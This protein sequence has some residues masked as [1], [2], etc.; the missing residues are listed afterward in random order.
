MPNNAGNTKNFWDSFIRA[1][2]AD[3]RTA[4]TIQGASGIQHPVDAIGM[5]EKYKRLIIVSNTVD[6]YSAA[7]VQADI[8]SA[9]DGIKVIVTRPIAISLS[10]TAQAL[11]TQMG[12]TSFNLTNLLEMFSDKEAAT[13][14]LE[15][16]IAP[17]VEMFRLSPINTT[18]K[19][20]QTIQ[21][22]TKIKF[23]F[24]LISGESPEMID[25]ETEDSINLANLINEDPMS[26]DRQL[27]VCPFPLYNFIGEEAEMFEM[28]THIQ[29]VKSIL[30]K[31]DILQYFY[32]SP[33]QVLLGLVDRGINQER[34]LTAEYYHVPILGHPYGPTEIIPQ[35]EN[36]KD[37]VQSLQER[38]FIVEGEFGYEIS[39]TGKS[40]RA[41]IKVKPREGLISKLLNR[42]SVNLNLDKLFPFKN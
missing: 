24:P 34:D 12:A 27:G 26:N 28:G 21:E 35:A 38:K 33:D 6:A 37:L 9:L 17:I 13:S 42:L 14:L 41:S 29:E 40:I 3:P 7:M 10:Q 31:H 30:Q 2:G 8:Q 23:S 20:V 39:D 4:N 11:S 36:F 22:L 25:K 15:P 18:A 5:D 32:P 1:V 19:I 16:I